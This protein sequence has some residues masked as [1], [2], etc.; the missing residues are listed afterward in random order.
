[1]AIWTPLFRATIREY[2]NRAR[3]RPKN[4]DRGVIA[5]D[6]MSY[7]AEKY[8]SSSR[9]YGGTTD[10]DAVISNL[11]EAAIAAGCLDAVHLVRRGDDTEDKPCLIPEKAT[12][13]QIIDMLEQASKQS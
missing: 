10:M 5:D 3:R 6:G 8:L 1:M 13:R 11:R 4:G 2:A 9:Q 12:N 7:V